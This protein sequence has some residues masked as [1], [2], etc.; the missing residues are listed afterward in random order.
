MWAK[1]S[2]RK[3]D[4]CG[5]GSVADSVSSLEKPFRSPRSTSARPDA[6]A[7]PF[8]LAHPLGE[9][10]LPGPVAHSLP[11]SQVGAGPE[12][13]CRLAWQPDRNDRSVPVS[14]QQVSAEQPGRAV[15]L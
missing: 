5:R 2:E 1:V 15:H 4:R 12:R 8:L 9:E 3:Q 10:L 6:S 14:G 7:T 13:A 11:G